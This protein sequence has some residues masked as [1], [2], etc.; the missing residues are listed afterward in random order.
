MKPLQKH[1]FFVITLLAA[2]SLYGQKQIVAIFPEPVEIS[3]SKGR[4]ILTPQT[5]IYVDNMETSGKDAAVF[6]EYLLENYGFSL[7]IKQSQQQDSNS[8]I[9][10]KSAD[11]QMPQDAYRLDISTGFIF[12]EGRDAGVFYAL[13]SLKQLLPDYKTDI[14]KIRNLKI[15]DYPAYSWRGMHLD[16]CRHFFTVEEVKKYIDL[17]AFYKMNTFHWH[18]TDDQ[19]WRIQIDKYPKL[20]SVGAYRN[21]TLIGHA[22]DTV[23]RYD[24][25]RYG[26]FY[27]KEQIRDVI[28][29]AAGRHVQVVPEIELPGHALAALSAYPEYSCT[30]GHFEV[31]GSWGVFD[32][33]FC[34]KDKTIRFLEDVLTE[35]ME[36]FPG[37]YIHIGGDECP[38]TRW[39]KCPE[40]RK[41]MKREGLKNS[42]QLQSYVIR[43]IEKF[44]NAKG[45]SIIG[46]DEILEG[47]LAPNA[48]VMSWR[49]ADGGVAAAKQKHNVVMC[50][51]NFCYF[52]HYQGDPAT[53]PLAFG[54]YTPLEKVYSYNPMP[55]SLPENLEKYILG[56][57]G[58]IWTEYI[59]D[60]D[61]VQYMALP[62]MIALSE[63]LWTNRKDRSYEQF[64]VRLQ[65]HTETLNMLKVKYR[66]LTK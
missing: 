47:G 46:W 44:V 6:N 11:G 21:R 57:Q 20:T 61:H 49:G 19:G 16:V 24:S 56:A 62:R 30:G 8:I 7:S 63:V 3:F 25:I 65:K 35:V 1:F 41:V 5:K 4:F 38:H 37:K 64:S 33:V 13:Q 43:T 59:P 34:T 51:G 58:N 12:I 66:N 26:G 54:G 17:L 23:Q 60:F 31:A 9:I 39:E 50:P 48:S 2:A 53:E 15:F 40:C 27:T 55:D 32:D 28:A 36:L 18:L 10:K 42:S 52:D 14:I 29:Y 22:A 45:K